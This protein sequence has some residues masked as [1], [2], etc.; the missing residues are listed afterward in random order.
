MSDDTK[1]EH[2]VV[3]Q[4]ET[5]TMT[6]TFEHDLKGHYI[7]A[8]E[9][10]QNDDGNM[11]LC[12]Y[13]NHGVFNVLI[14][15]REKVILDLNVNEVTRSSGVPGQEDINIDASTRPNDNFPDPFCNA[16]FTENGTIFVNV[17]HAKSHCMFHFTYSIPDK[18]VTNACVKTQLDDN[19]RDF[20]LNCYYDKTRNYVYIFYRQGM[21]YMI[22]I[23]DFKRVM[24][25]TISEFDI[26]STLLYND[27]VM[28]VKS[29][30]Q[31]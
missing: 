11:F 12:P 20:P 25:Q 7:K 28:M 30:S 8:K 15:D 5:E 19:T 13:L 4:Y 24:K 22:P 21:S 14:F 16:C 31:L 29:S 9:I 3:R 6:K 1:D 18:K 27:K 10:V 23:E 26:G 2:Y 17:Y